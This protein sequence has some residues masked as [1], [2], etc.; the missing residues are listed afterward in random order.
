MTNNT[1]SIRPPASLPATAATIAAG[2]GQLLV[3]YFTLAAIG[4]IGVPLWGIILLASAWL[5]ATA[6]LVRLAQR[7]PLLT[8][9]VPAAN[10][11]VLWGFVAA[12]GAW[13]GWSA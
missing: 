1:A 6:I 4:L 13:F 5:A 3:G 2:A 11:L 7:R 10:A 9:V 8:L 12:G